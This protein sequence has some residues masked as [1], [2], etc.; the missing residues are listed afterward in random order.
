MQIARN[1]HAIQ[2]FS[3]TPPGRSPPELRHLDGWTARREIETRQYID[4]RERLGRVN[5]HVKI[6][7]AACG[8][9]NI[10]FILFYNLC[11]MTGLTHRAS[12]SFTG[13]L[14]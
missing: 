3:R 12:C 9:N 5:P 2:D 10:Y 11:H 7:S 14:H 8:S 13:N 6:R 1:S 4:R